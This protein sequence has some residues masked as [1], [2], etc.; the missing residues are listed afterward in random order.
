MLAAATAA[1]TTTALATRK[2]PALVRSN[3]LRYCWLD[4]VQRASNGVRETMM[5]NGT[6]PRF[7]SLAGWEF[8]GANGS[9]VTRVI[10]IRKFAKGFYVGPDRANGPS[11][12]LQG[13]N[14]NVR[15]NRDEAEHVYLTREDGSPQRHGYYRVHA[16]IEGAKDSYYPNALLLDYALGGNGPFGPPLRDY[17][18]QVYPDNP[19]LL[20][21][22]AY[23]ALGPLRISAGFFILE[24]MKR[25]DHHG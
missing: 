23:L 3:G 20:L 7:E 17:I 5:R 16:P 9:I 15:Q 24:R 21:G 19:D 22:K 6:A 2:S 4:L 13:Y 12:H 11:P 25:H 1:A 14:V 10:G 18:V 8:R